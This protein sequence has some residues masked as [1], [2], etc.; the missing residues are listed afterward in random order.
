MHR[1]DIVRVAIERLGELRDAVNA[2]SL[3]SI[4]TDAGPAVCAIELSRHPVTLAVRVGT[5][6]PLA[7][8][9]T[10]RIF[11]AFGEPGA[12]SA[13]DVTAHV[14]ATGVATVDQTFL[15]GVQAVAAPLRRAD[16]RLAAAITVIG[17]PGAF[18]LDE[19]GAIAT[20]LLAFI[21]QLDPR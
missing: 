12:A 5:T 4:W 15:V 11:L 2:T 19:H 6:F 20:G 14:R 21:A 17:S 9:A 3:I 7:N 18:D 16:G 10:G 13:D 8:S 1:F